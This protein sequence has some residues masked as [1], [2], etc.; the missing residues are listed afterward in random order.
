MHWK[1]H[2]LDSVDV[3]YGKAFEINFTEL[4]LK[5]QFS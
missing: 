2:R 3:G 4:L 1:N 5:I